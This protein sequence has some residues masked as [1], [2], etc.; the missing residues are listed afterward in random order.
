MSS[1]REKVTVSGEWKE[2]DYDGAMIVKFLEDMVQIML[3]ILDRD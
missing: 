3:S 1:W 2:C